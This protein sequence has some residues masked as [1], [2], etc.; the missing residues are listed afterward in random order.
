MAS[1]E[2]REAK[3]MEIMNMRRKGAIESKIMR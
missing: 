3:R 2:G 1:T